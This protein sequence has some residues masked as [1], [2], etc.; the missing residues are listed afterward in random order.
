VVLLLLC[1][2]T[3]PKHIEL[4][5]FLSEQFKR[6]LLLLLV[7]R[8]EYIVAHRQGYRDRL[9]LDDWLTDRD[10]LLWLE[11]IVYR[12]DRRNNH[13][14]GNFRFC[15]IPKWVVLV[16]DVCLLLGCDCNFLV[17]ERKEILEL[18]NVVLPRLSLRFTN[19]LVFLPAI[20]GGSSHI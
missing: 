13:R 9:A 12:L 19:H 3:G 20:L 5:R 16:F 18:F 8:C 7:H 1:I 10:I 6:L 11:E 4:C 17:S 2:V 14:R 15:E